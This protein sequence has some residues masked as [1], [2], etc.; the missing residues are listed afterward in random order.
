MIKWEENKNE[1]EKNPY[2]G[3]AVTRIS[4]GVEITRVH[5]EVD[6]FEFLSDLSPI[7]GYACQ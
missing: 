5:G 3:Q 1:N 2:C 4:G 6:F 7:I